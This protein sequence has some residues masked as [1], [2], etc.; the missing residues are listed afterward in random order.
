MSKPSHPAP[1]YRKHTTRNLAVVTLSD[2][3]SGRRRNYYLGPFDASASR[4]KYHRLVAAWEASGRR[5]PNEP[6]RENPRAAS[7]SI[8]VGQLSLEYWRFAKDYYTPSEAASIKSAIR[9]LNQ[10]AGAKL[11]AEFGP[12]LL[13]LVR[14]AMVR[15]D[16]KADPPRRPWARTHINDQVQRLCAIFRWGASQ[17]MLPVTVYQQLKTVPPLKKGKSCARESETVRPVSMEMVAVV[18]SFLS[19]Q[20]NALVDLQILTGARGGELL[21]LRPR[22]I[23]RSRPIW[24]HKPK[25]HKTAWRGKNRTILFGP[26]AQAILAPFLMRSDDAFMFSPAEAERER[27]KDAH[28]ARKTPDGCGNTPGS[29]VKKEPKCAPGEHYTNNSYRQAVQRA[30]VKAFPF[31]PALVRRKVPSSKGEKSRRWETTA[32][33]RK[34]LG[35]AKWEQLQKWL[36]EHRWHPHQLR[37]TTATLIRR[38]FGLE[39]AQVALGHGSAVVTDAV[40][41]ER[42]LA[43]IEEVMLK[44]G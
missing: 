40:Y 8:S 42:D 9:V 22:D 31:P 38:E 41:A 15:G 37:H 36:H 10:L 7:S 27:R 28:E 23:D 25:D 29:N 24:Q 32:E 43:K 5:L 26:K 13:R 33:W 20:V 1:D 2:A 39:A 12:S 16:A 17:E 18:R 4:E 19:R 34:R 3:V 44:I 35:E 14:E 11:A 6:D 21:K 30:C